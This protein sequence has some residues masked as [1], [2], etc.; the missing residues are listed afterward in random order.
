MKLCLKISLK[1]C[2]IVYPW[3]QCLIR[4]IKLY[5]KFC[6]SSQIHQHPLPMI[7]VDAFLYDDDFVDSLCEEGKM[8]RSYCT[9]CGSYK[10]ASLEFISHSFSLMELKFLYQH[11]LPDLT[12]KVV[13]DVGSRLGAVLFAGYLYSSASQLYGVEMNADFC[14]LQEMMVTKYQFIDRIK[15]VHADICTQASLL[16]K[17]DVVVMNNVFEYFLD[18][19][20]QARAWEFVACNVR[21]TGSLLVTVPSL[22]ES[23]SKVQTDIQLGQWVEEMQLNYD[24]YVE[25]D[26]D[27]EALEQIHLYKIL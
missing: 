11:V 24:V 5:R 8:S 25:K 16:Q 14:Q 23:L 19:Q 13:V 22:T 6:S 21:K 1:I 7:H 9:E 27:R 12:G 2:G 20:E 15:V 17:A 18:R 4:N 10:T 3:R 26:V